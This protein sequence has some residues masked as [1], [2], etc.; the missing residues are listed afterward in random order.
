MSERHEIGRQARDLRALLGNG[1]AVF[2]D[3]SVAVAEAERD[4]RKAKAEAWAR[5]AGE[6]LA[7]ERAAQVDADT[8]DLRFARDLAD[9]QSRA[10]RLAVQVRL[11]ELD[12][13]RSEYSALR[14]DMRLAE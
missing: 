2:R 4:Y 10:A 8:A 5:R 11:A 7:G 1:L 14:T 6:G 3:Q 12:F 9:A 13:L